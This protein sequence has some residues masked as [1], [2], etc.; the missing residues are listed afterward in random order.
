MT[1]D[2]VTRKLTSDSG[3]IHRKDDT[4]YCDHAIYLGINDL[5]D[6]YEEG[7]AEDYLLWQNKEEQGE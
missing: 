6:N 7:N 3:Y 4:L 1:F 5:P 2:Q